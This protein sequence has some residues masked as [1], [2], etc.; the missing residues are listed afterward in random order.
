VQLCTLKFLGTFL[1]DPSQIP[2]IAVKHIADQLGITDLDRAHMNMLGR[3]DFTISPD[4]A[5]GDLRPLRD[6]NAF[7]ADKPFE[8]LTMV[9][10]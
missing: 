6:P 5:G 7:L 8:A 2:E 1:T 3:F 4:V 9:P 10:A